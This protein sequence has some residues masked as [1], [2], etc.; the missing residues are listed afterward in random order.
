MKKLVTTVISNF[1]SNKKLIELK[2]E[3]VWLKVFAEQ[4]VLLITFVIYICYL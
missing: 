1:N 3:Y 2:Y 4:K